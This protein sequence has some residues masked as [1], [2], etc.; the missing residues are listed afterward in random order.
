MHIVSPLNGETFAVNNSPRR[1]CQIDIYRRGRSG[2]SCVQVIQLRAG[3]TNIESMNSSAF[4]IQQLLAG[5]EVFSIYVL[6]ET[7]DEKRTAKNDVPTKHPK[8]N[9]SNKTLAEKRDAKN[10]IPTEHPKS[11][12]SNNT[13]AENR[14]AKND[15]PPEHPKSDDSKNTLAEKREAISGIP[16]DN[17]NNSKSKAQTEKEDVSCHLTEVTR[18]YQPLYCS[19]ECSVLG[20]ADLLDID[21]LNTSGQLAI[22]SNSRTCTLFCWLYIVIR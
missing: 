2:Y 11:N 8:S 14:D 21:V 4:V 22:S 1:S 3:I 9:D 12:D 16:T 20:K 5:R 17:S 19:D 10:D 6:N 18:M 13:S 15:I 7:S